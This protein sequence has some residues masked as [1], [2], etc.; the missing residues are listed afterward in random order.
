MSGLGRVSAAVQHQLY[1]AFVDGAVSVDEQRRAMESLMRLEGID[2]NDGL[3]C[4]T[5]TATD[6]AGGFEVVTRIVLPQRPT[7]AREQPLTA[8]ALQQYRVDD[9][10][11]TNLRQLKLL[12]F[13]AVVVLGHLL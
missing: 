2:L 3:D 4:H 1:E 5:T 11:F 8:D 12:I 7:V 10:S 9:G 6:G 13:R